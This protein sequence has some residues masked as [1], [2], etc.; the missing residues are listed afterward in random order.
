VVF[1]YYVGSGFQLVDVVVLG[2]FY[3]NG[4]VRKEHF[5]KKH[6]NI[7]VVDN[8][9]KLRESI[10]ELLSFPGNTIMEIVA[11]IDR[12][13]GKNLAPLLFHYLIMNLMEAHLLRSHI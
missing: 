13:S 5:L 4:Q 10:I 11:E 7:F 8:K 2:H 3:I 1:R 9:Q 6:H 12:C